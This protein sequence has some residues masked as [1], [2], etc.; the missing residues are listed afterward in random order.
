MNYNYQNNH[1]DHYSH[2]GK[3]QKKLSKIIPKI[4]LITIIIKI[5]IFLKN[6]III[7]KITISLPSLVMAVLLL[8]ESTSM[9]E[10]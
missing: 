7:P 6:K 4:I 1:F 9:V 5:T 8:P 10:R 2:F 3:E